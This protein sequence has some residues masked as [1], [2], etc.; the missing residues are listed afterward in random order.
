MTTA[1]QS[2]NPVTK[3]ELA[4]LGIILMIGGSLLLPALSTSRDSARANLCRRNLRWLDLSARDYVDAH[5]KLPSALTWP[6]DILSYFGPGYGNERRPTGV[7]VVTMPRP[8]FY[9]CPA[10]SDIG[11]RA[12]EIQPIHYALIV[13]RNQNVHSNRMTWKFRDRA[14]VV[15]D[16]APQHWYVGYEMSPEAAEEQLHSRLGPHADGAYHESD[17]RGATTIRK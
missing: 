15:D 12:G 14:L 1:T 8:I 10:R 6:H 4:V 11:D 9:T 7:M 16:G 17:G 3:S 5:Q 2:S 13:D